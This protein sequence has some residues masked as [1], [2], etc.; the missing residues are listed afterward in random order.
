MEFSA[1]DLAWESVNVLR[2]LTAKVF[3]QLE[4]QGGKRP[5]RPDGPES[6]KLRHALRKFASDSITGIV[7]VG[8]GAPAQRSSV[9]GRSKFGTISGLIRAFKDDPSSGYSQLSLTTRS[10][11][12]RM[13]ARF[14]REIG[15]VPLDETLTMEQILGWYARWS[16]NGKHLSYGYAHLDRVR[17]LLR[18]G[19]RAEDSTC[20]RL[21]GALRAS[22]FPTRS[23]GHRPK[24][25]TAAQ[26]DAIR[27]LAHKKKF[28]SLALAQAFQF[29][30]KLFEAQ[31]IGEWLPPSAPGKTLL[32]GRTIVYRFN[33]KRPRDEK[34]VRGLLWSQICDDYTLRRAVD[35]EVV[36]IDLKRYPM[37]MAE[38]KRIGKLPKDG[39]VVVWE[40]TGSP[41][42]MA[43]YRYLWRSI[44]NQ[45]GVPK[46]VRN[47]SGKRRDANIGNEMM[48]SKEELSGK[49]RTIC[50]AIPA[51]I[52][53]CVANEMVVD[54]LAG[55]VTAAELE[56]ACPQYSGAIA[57]P[58]TIGSG[59]FHLI[60][61]CRGLRTCV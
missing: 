15:E 60:S 55:D 42:T 27:A 25:I 1:I 46:N 47:V 3:E 59:T 29:D 58:L 17:A 16:A 18:Y 52:R 20:N 36:K 22:M 56:K 34:W 8:S 61:D 37:I 35:G 23:S 14:E 39:P 13:Y 6:I 30:L 53:D 32:Q 40:K 2:E 44:A 43:Q 10:N 11:Q 28:H 26:A 57:P 12:D 41:Y 7:V 21:N 38:L 51:D 24:R 5:A 48:P 50:E 31:V 9:D 19:A 49:V 45:A 33:A 4:Q 54:L